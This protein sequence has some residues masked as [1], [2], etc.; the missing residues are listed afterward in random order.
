[1]KKFLSY[2]GIFSLS[3]ILLAGGIEYMLRQVPN[4]LAY[5]RC[6]LEKNTLNLKTLI[7]GSSVVNCSINPVFLSDSTYNLA[8]SGEWFRFNQALLEKHIDK[9]PSLKFVI[10]GICFHSLWTDD[11][12]E[13]DESSLINHKIYMDITREDDY[14]HNVELPYLGSL[15]LRKWSKYYIQRKPTVFCDS[16]GLDH[17]Y[18]HIYKSARWLEDIP[19]MV[20][21]Q[22]KPILADKDSKL[23]QS[24]I[25]R[26]HKVAEL[27]HKRGIHLYLVMPPVHPEYY[28]LADKKQLE[29]IRKAVAEVV[30]C[31]DNVSSHEYFDDCRFTD[32]DFYD[33][34]H[35]NSDIGA[36]K[37]STILKNDLSVA[38][39]N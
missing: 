33:G 16:L 20:R 21:N 36:K 2:V 10:W 22:H 5:K 31:W 7:I 14:F 24:N 1:M 37:F 15:A 8:I 4:P 28:R 30:S 17:S 23:Y 12:E 34:N 35:L 26:M 3:L 18:D 19:R 25:C 32:D 38:G 13:V 9:M 39:Y 27:C 11:C 29:L 6:L